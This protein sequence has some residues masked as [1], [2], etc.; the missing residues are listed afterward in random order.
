MKNLKVAIALA[1]GGLLATFA[2][3]EKPAQAQE[4]EISKIV[5]TC[6]S[7]HGQGGNS[8]SADFPR[9][10]GQQPAYLIERFKSFRDPTTQSTHA[11]NNMWP[12]ATNVADQIIPAL[13]QYFA[14]Q[15]PVQ[16]KGSGPLLAEGERL[17]K[18]G[19]PGIPACQTCHG[20]NAEGKGTIP[21]LAGQHA[22]YLKTQL[23]V[24]N[25]ML[26]DSNA[27]HSNVKNMT[28]DQ[29]SAVVAYLANG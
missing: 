15:P 8:V 10:N 24:F 1:S 11:S 13:A 20:A 18:N 17:F 28:D 5:S 3:A 6:E 19:A 2:M 27:M 21:R 26:R 7:C 23:S 9:L 4:G 14:S 12:V 29:I 22:E 16:P 25:F